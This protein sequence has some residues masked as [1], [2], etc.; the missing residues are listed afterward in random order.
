MHR[1]L[2]MQQNISNYNVTANG[3]IAV[4]HRSIHSTRSVDYIHAE[5]CCL[6]A[7]LLIG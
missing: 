2:M 7:W 4:S 1:N 5:K 3:N 6:E